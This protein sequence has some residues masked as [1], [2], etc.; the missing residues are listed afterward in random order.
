MRRPARAVGENA[1]DPSIEETHGFDM[2][3]VAAR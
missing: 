1:C 2:L 3:A